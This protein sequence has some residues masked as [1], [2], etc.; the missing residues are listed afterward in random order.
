[1]RDDFSRFT[2]VF[3]LRTKYE[4]A[5]YFAENQ[6][7]A[8]IAPCKAEVVRSDGGGKFLEGDFGAP[9]Y[10]S[11][12]ERQIT[13]I[14]AAGLAARIQAVAKYPNKVFPRG[15]F[16][17]RATHQIARQHQLTPDLSPPMRCGLAHPQLAALYPS[18]SRAF[19]T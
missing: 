5:R 1:M 4:T 6:Y 13:I 19:A 16:V 14:K 8:E 7:L 3:F 18:S 11:V 15:E 9:Q 17:S 12:A 10:N 2:R